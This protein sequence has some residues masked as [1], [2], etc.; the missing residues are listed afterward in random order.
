ML[1]EGSIVRAVEITQ[2]NPKSWIFQLEKEGEKS[3]HLGRIDHDKIIGKKYGNVV[4]LIKGHVLL[5]KP[6]PRDFLRSFRLKTQIMYEDDC[7][8]ACSVAGIGNGMKV[9]EAGTGSGALTSFLA[10]N[11]APDGHVYSFDINEKHLRNAEQNIQMTGLQNIITFQIHDIRES[12]QVP[13]LDAFFLDFSTPFEAID[14][15]TPSVIGGGH[16]ICFVPNWGQ[17]EQTV[18]KINENEALELQQVFEV[19]RRDFTINPKKHIMRPK[20]RSIVYSGIL[21]HAIKI[22]F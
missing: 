21:I 18:E 17:V 16:L 2:K 19:N 11:V 13:A 3:T 10:W 12:I 9:G 14:S 1:K 8:L 15:I 22:L 20:F 7:A 6:S 4:S 5:L